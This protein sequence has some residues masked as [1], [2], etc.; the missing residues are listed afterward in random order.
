MAASTPGPTFTVTFDDA[1]LAEDLAHTSAPGRAVAVD[2]RGQLAANGIPAA[3]L[4][5]CLSEGR[6]GTQCPAASRPTCPHP[7]ATGAWPFEGRINTDGQPF[8]HCLAFGR[9]HPARASEPSVYQLAHQRL[10]RHQDR[11]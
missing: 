9:R 7:P 10:R 2:A 3:L 11:G 4:R 8:L 6:D 1:A 5:P